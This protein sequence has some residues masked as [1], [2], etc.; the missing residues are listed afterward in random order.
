M[1]LDSSQPKRDPELMQARLS[2]RLSYSDPD[3]T[4]SRW[5]PF[6]PASQG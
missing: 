1:A 6:L 3:L 2:T 4:L 5:C